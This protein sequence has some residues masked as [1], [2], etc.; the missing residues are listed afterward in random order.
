MVQSE[1][2]R[3]LVLRGW[4][5]LLCLWL[6]WSLWSPVRSVIESNWT[7]S[8]INRILEQHVRILSLVYFRTGPRVCS[9]NSR[10]S[11]T[12]VLGVKVSECTRVVSTEAPWL[13]DS[14]LG[15]AGIRCYLGRSA[16]AVYCLQNTVGNTAASVCGLKLFW[17][18]FQVIVHI[19]RSTWLSDV[20]NIHKSIEDMIWELTQS[21]LTLWQKS[22]MGWAGSQP[23][24]EST[25]R[26]CSQQPS[27]HL[28]AAQ[29][30][31][32]FTFS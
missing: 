30:D 23:Q 14:S 12:G 7:F 29:P 26:V 5:T 16:N 22:M 28:A 27:I 32:L 15:P 8:S 19:V 6:S 11:E 4:C 9:F 20:Y 17:R 24:W 2:D 18:G 21:Q 1:G 13:P 25:E 3:L 10:L 31:L